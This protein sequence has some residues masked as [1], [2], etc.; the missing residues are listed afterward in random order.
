MYCV[1]LLDVRVCS[2]LLGSSFGCAGMTTFAILGFFVGLAS[3]FLLRLPLFGVVLVGYSVAS[4][5]ATTMTGWPIAS[6]LLYVVLCQVGYVVGILVRAIIAHFW[7][8]HSK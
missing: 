3:S 5:V 4:A 8:G 2:R 6:V 1:W 7:S